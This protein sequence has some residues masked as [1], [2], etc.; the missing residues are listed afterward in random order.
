MPICYFLPGFLGSGLSL[1]APGLDPLWVSYTRLA[2]GE[3]GGMRLAADGIAPQPPDGRPLFVQAPLFDYYGRA[4][5]ILRDQLGPHRYAVVAWGWDWRKTIIAQ[6]EAL[7]AAIRA[8]SFPDDPAAIVGHSA[9][10]LVARAAWLSLLRSEQSNLIRRI[11]TLGTPHQGTYDVVAL[12]SLDTPQLDQ[13]SWLTL[14]VAAGTRQVPLPA[15]GRYW[16]VLDMVQLASTWPALYELLPTLGTP[17]AADDPQRFHLYDVAKWPSNRGISQAWLNHSRNTFG[18]F[19]RDPASMPPTH[20]LTTLAGIQTPTADKLLYVSDLG[21]PRAYGR[22]DDGDGVVTRSSALVD[23]SASY[24]LN[25]P[26]SN[27]PLDAVLYA[28]LAG[29]VLATRPPLTPPPPIVTA[30]AP[31]QAP[32]A[33]PP[34]PSTPYAQPSRSRLWSAACCGQC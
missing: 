13:V 9:G 21:Q 31:P 34:I 25:S 32:L 26:H 33:G 28:D 16:S 12:W 3:G 2:Y 19:L 30:T 20:I 23:D 15:K 14:A 8:H 17:T 5:N 6:G 22:T 11:V 1:D 27:L 4:A 24:Q 18:S 10:G 29:L 7:A